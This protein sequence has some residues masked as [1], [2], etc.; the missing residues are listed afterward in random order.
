MPQRMILPALGLIISY[1]QCYRFGDVGGEKNYKLVGNG[2]G[3]G[4]F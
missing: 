2:V 3:G 4:R 1:T